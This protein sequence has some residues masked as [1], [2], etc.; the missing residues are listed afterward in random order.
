MND[1]FRTRS[2]G[3]FYQGFFAV[4]VI[5][6]PTF[7]EKAEDFLTTNAYSSLRASRTD[8]V[9]RGSSIS[10]FTL[11]SV[12]LALRRLFFFSIV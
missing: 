5:G 4:G 7:R 9:N 1:Q 10:L 11:E 2:A 12:I 3:D 6:A 8:S